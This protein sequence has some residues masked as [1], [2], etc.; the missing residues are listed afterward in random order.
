MT[1]ETTLPPNT[2]RT[3]L[4]RAYTTISA[5][6]AVH[7]IAATGIGAFV[8]ATR[9][10]GSVVERIGKFTVG[11]G[12]ALWGPGLVIRWLNL[13]AEPQFIGALGF[14]FGYFGM[15]ITDALQTTLE[16]IARN[17]KEIDWK[18]IATGWLTRK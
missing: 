16:N 14:V 10:N 9:M 1:D 18:A 3:F 8:A 15:T 2:P 6:S 17:L 7:T 11:F 5:W 4:L 12:C 13:P